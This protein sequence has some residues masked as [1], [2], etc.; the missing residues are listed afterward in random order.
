MDKM[1]KNIYIVIGKFKR[2][3]T[4]DETLT[5][6]KTIGSPTTAKKLSK[7]LK[8]NEKTVMKRVRRLESQKKVYRT[9]KNGTKNGRYLLI[10]LGERK[11]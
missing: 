6:I 3:K 8:I 11:K 4:D 5:A 2:K 7:K 9:P 1:R 10:Y